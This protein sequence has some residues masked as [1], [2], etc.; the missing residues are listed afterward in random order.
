M[1]SLPKDGAPRQW[2]GLR[3]QGARVWG[4]P[5]TRPPVETILLFRALVFKRAGNWFPVVAFRRVPP[6]PRD[7]F[8]TRCVATLA[9]A[10]RFSLHPTPLLR[11]A[12]ANVGAIA[13]FLFRFVARPLVGNLKKSFALPFVLVLVV[14]DREDALVSLLRRASGEMR[15]IQNGMRGHRIVRSKQSTP[16][17]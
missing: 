15:T 2:H 17:S 12:T 10:R 16:S 9:Q 8:E 3:S 5:V 1:R 6:T 11:M 13:W 4:T 7:S 14:A